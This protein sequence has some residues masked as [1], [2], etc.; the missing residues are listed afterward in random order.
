MIGSVT[1]KCARER[2]LVKGRDRQSEDRY[3]GAWVRERTRGLAEERE[4]ESE[5]RY[6][7]AWVRVRTR[8]SDGARERER[9]ARL[10]EDRVGG[11]EPVGR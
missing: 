10:Q 8:A 7:G 5:D 3:S 1:H 11:T 2:M 6:S 4:E 9:V